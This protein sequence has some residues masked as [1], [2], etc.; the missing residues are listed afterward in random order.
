[1]KKWILMIAAALLIAGIA[2]FALLPVRSIHYDG[3]SVYT[4]QE[5]NRLI[6]GSESPK[7]YP[8]RLK[9]LFTKHSEIPFLA[10]YDLV[11]EGDR[12]ITVHL[13]EKSLAGYIRFQS[14]FLYFDWDGVIVEIGTQAL[15]GLYEVRGLPVEH[16]VKGEVLPVSDSGVM[17]TILTLNQ[18]LNRVTIR[19]GGRAC[20][21]GELCEGIRFKDG[22]VQLEF[23]D[24]SVYLGSSETMEG[25]LYAMEDILPELEGKKG[26]LYLDNYQAGEL[27]P[28]YVFKE[29]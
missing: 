12:S 13:Y 22:A 4:E 8:V 14:Y 20:L 25:K 27:R 19:W 18:F 15:D 26:I 5:L 2:V 11:F 16:A 10:R 29:N 3:E 23:G 17:H 6:F 1:M 7:Y 9:E 24:I 21:I 28:S